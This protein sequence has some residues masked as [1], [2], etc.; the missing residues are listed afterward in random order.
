VTV[1]VTIIELTLH[2]TDRFLE[3]ELLLEL[4]RFASAFD[5]WNASSILDSSSVSK[6]FSQSRR[7]DSC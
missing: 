1:P 6:M 3:D 4:S 7:Q 5:E 2:R